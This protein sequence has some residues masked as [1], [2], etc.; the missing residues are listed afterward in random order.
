MMVVF[1]GFSMLALILVCL[2]RDD[3]HSLDLSLYPELKLSVEFAYEV[4][5]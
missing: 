1:G 5:K 3:L 2:S 4:K